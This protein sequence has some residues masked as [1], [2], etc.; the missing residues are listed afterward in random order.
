[1]DTR[2]KILDA[3]RAAEVVKSGA[4]V[5]AGYFDPLIAWHSRWLAMFKKS[6]RPLLVLIASPENPILPP[7]ARCELVASLRVVDYVCEFAPEL[8]ANA[9]RL[10]SQDRELF[11]DLLK[12]VH[13]RNQAVPAQA[14]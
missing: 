7:A 6:D 9:S 4:T 1:M 8:A 3:A 2:S 5:V 11:G 12:L 14:N 13:S 10:E